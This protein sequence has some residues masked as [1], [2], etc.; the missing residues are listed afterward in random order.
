MIILSTKGGDILS[1]KKIGRPTNNPKPTKLTIR[2]DDE[3]ISIL[4]EYCEINGLSRAQ[5]VRI[6]IK[7]LKDDA[8]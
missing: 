4:D 5:G 8:K 2:V 1:D 3:A 7:R 6:G